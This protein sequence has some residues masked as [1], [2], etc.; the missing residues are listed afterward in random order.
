KEKVTTDGNCGLVDNGPAASATTVISPAAGIGSPHVRA[1]SAGRSDPAPSRH[2]AWQSITDVAGSDGYGCAQ[3]PR[4]GA[5][6]NFGEMAPRLVQNGYSPVPLH[7]DYGRPAINRWDNLRQTPLSAGRILELSH[8]A[9]YG[10]GVV[11]GFKGLVPI[12]ID[13]DDP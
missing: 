7:P 6:T 2:L 13:T 5:V 3:K 9:D 1:T 12:D 4:N 11:G 10:L 8:K